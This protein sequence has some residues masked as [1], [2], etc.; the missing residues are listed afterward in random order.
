MAD[1]TFPPLKS[2]DAFSPRGLAGK[3]EYVAGLEARGDQ[4]SLRLL[5]ECLADESGY[6]RDLAEGALVR[7]RADAEPIL[8]LLESGLWYTRV[9][10]VRTLGRLGAR[11]AARP[12]SLLLRDPNQSVTREAVHALTRLVRAG[13]AVP[14]ARALFRLDGALRARAQGELIGA[15]REA[16]LEVEELLKDRELMEA[17]DAEVLTED[18]AVA[19]SDEGLAWDVLT[20]VHH[21]AGAPRAQR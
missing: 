14:V 20:S 19:R 9:S 5:V 4:E 18:P 13:G 12:L 7:L 10:A 16:A 3:R 21:P 11:K 6:L 2:L 8:P 15:D 1:E 17:E